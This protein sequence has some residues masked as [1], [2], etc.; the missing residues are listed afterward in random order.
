MKYSY[1]TYAYAFKKTFQ[2]LLLIFGISAAINAQTIQIS[3]KVTSNGSDSAVS[4][5]SIKI[6]GSNKAR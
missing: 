2:I 6:K 5:A 1:I 3:G 4:G